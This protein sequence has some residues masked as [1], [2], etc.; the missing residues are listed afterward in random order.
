MTGVDVLGHQNATA[1]EDLSVSI[2]LEASFEWMDVIDGDIAKD[3]A[4]NELSAIRRHIDHDARAVAE[5][6]RMVLLEFWF[7]EVARVEPPDPSVSLLGAFKA[8]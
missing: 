7:G 3:L 8:R 1:A 6:P 5:S 4:R 2:D